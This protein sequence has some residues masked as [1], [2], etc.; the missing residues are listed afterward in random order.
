MRSQRIK[1]NDYEN[2]QQIKSLN[3]FGKY[4]QMAALFIRNILQKGM[5]LYCLQE[6]G[7]NWR[8]SS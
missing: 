8:S 3:K 5:K 6:N 2:N 7:W 4:K 1:K